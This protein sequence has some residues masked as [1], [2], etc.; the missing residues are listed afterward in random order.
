MMYR[1]TWMYIAIH[2]VLLGVEDL[3]PI[4]DQE[5]PVLTNAPL[6]PVQEGLSLA[7]FLLYRR[8]RRI[9]EAREL[10]AK[11]RQE[12]TTRPICSPN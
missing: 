9:R 8:Q 1:D 12:I 11:E 3:L 5:L 6:P 2:A 4:L 10:L 7:G